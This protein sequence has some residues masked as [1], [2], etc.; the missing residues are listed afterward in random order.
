MF[1]RLD[2]GLW[3]DRAWTLIEGCTPVSEGCDHCW[4]A[5]MTHRFHSLKTL[6]TKSKGS[7]SG[8]INTR[9]DRLD[10]PLRVKKPTAW[11]VWNDLFHEDVPLPFIVEALNTMACATLS[12][13]RRHE[14]EDEC[15]SGEPHIFLILTKR[16]DRAYEILHVELP[17]FVG[18]NYSGDFPLSVA[19]EVNWPLPNLWLGVTAENQEQADRRIPLLLQTPAAVRFVSVEPMLGKINLNKVA[20]DGVFLDALK[21]IR[22]DYGLNGYGLAAPMPKKLHWVICGGESGPHARPLHP[23]WARS[24]RDQCRGAGVPF[25]FKQQGEWCAELEMAAPDLFWD[26]NGAKLWGTLDYDGNWF[27]ETTPWNGRQGEDSPENELVM[28]RVGKKTAGRLLDGRTWNEVPN[29][30]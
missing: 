13:N 9:E 27:P 24:L 23:D 5:T 6:L 21:G 22:F 7:F 14:H 18:H 30:R 2:Q 10:L 11:A 26:G 1:N 3:W 4:S 19:L 29:V 15:W 20:G 16:I 12:C 28:Y 17:E 25:Y 8:A